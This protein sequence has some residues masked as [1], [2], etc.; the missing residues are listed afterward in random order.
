METE[1]HQTAQHETTDANISALVKFCIGLFLLIV[2]ALFG[3]R[4]M[5][6]YFNRTRQLGP[7]ASPFAY[8]KAA[9]PGPGL[10]VHPAQDLKR[11]VLG[12]DEKLNSYGWVDQKAGIARIPIDRAMDLLIEKG[13]PV[14]GASA[15]KP[16][17]K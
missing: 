5:F 4:L 7:A 2:A 14:R 6:S 15:P 8:T 9:P 13:L 16:M 17:G 12:E 10:Q 1:R 11:L 3:M